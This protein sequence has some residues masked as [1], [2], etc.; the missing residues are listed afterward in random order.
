MYACMHACMYVCIKLESYLAYESPFFFLVSAL[1][2]IKL[3]NI[4]CLI[5]PYV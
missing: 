2:R 5:Y 1:F 4:R 3:I